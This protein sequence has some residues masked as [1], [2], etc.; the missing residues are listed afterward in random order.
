MP[1]TDMPTVTTREHD[2][3]TIWRCE[4]CG[5]LVCHWCESA[6]ACNKKKGRS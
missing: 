3:R 5:K 2:E 1:F 4:S 6:H